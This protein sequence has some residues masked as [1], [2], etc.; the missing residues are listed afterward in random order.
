MRQSVLV[1]ALAGLVMIAGCKK[2]VAPPPPP[3]PA[4]AAPATPP[5]APEPPPT[6]EV[7]PVEDEYSRM[8]KM[9]TD[10]IERMGLL[11]EIHFDYDSADIREGDRQVL[12]RNADA[13]KRFDFLRVTLEGHADERG[14]V[15]Y[16][17]ALGER[18]AKAAYDYLVS[19][20]VP[21]ERLKTVSYGKEVPLCQQSSVDCWARN[22]RVHFAVTGKV[23]QP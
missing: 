20:G 2:R 10:E 9:A 5:P 6:R 3:P 12:S 7:A 1:V 16:N 14:T 23:R 8:R 17:L 4:P 18:R 15:E 11:A 22:R 13:L 19:L 21:A